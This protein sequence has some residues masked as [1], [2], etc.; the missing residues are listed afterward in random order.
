MTTQT[1]THLEQAIEEGHAKIV[2]EG[3]T[4]RIHYVV[5]NHSEQWSDQEEKVHAEF[6]T[7]LIYGLNSR[8]RL[9]LFPKPCLN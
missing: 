1:K 4:Q 9:F 7:E 5:S 2:G 8:R 6:W 3:K